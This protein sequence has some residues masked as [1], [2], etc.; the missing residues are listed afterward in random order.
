MNYCKNCGNRLA[1]SEN[2]CRNCGTPTSSVQNTVEIKPG[3]DANAT[4]G[5]LLS[6]VPIVFVVGLMIFI[7]LMF[8]YFLG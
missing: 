8:G 3:N 2:F 7:I 5:L 4:I 1:S 6:W